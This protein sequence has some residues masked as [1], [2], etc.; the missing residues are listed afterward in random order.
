MGLDIYFYRV[1]TKKLAQDFI[2][3]SKAY[4]VTYDKYYAKYK[5]QLKKA[6]EKWDKWYESEWDRISKY[7]D[8]H[9]DEEPIDIDYSTEP[10]YSITD[11][12]DELEQAKSKQRE[13]SAFDEQVFH[14]YLQAIDQKEEAD[15]GE[16]T[17]D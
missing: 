7:A 11:Y 1:K 8:E 16:H 4:D 6:S 17:E 12:L 10:K 3:A 2:A 14:K 13:S 15:D 5:P 9:P